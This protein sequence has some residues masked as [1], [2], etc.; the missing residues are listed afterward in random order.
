MKGR[1]NEEWATRFPKRCPY[2]L[3]S[4]ALH[5][6]TGAL[7]FGMIVYTTLQYSHLPEQIPMHFNFAGE[8][9][10]YGSKS[11]VVVLVAMAAGLWLT[12]LA[13]G[14]FPRFW[15]VPVHLHQGNRIAVCQWTRRFLCI[16][17]LLT[18]IIFWIVLLMVSG[19]DLS[20]FI[21]V[22]LVFMGLATLAYIV[23]VHRL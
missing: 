6:L 9:D 17:N 8:A 2:D 7:L 1:K 21:L 15:N 11:S 13:A 5:I 18:V 23:F 3:F 10:A 19:Y 20:V 14:H 12:M 22:D 4:V 16:I